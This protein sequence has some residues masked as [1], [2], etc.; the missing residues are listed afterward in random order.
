MHT[1]M[2]AGETATAEPLPTD[3]TDVS[4]P[5]RS[6][7]AATACAWIAP[8]AVLLLSAARAIAGSYPFEL[9]CHFQLQY[10]IASIVMVLLLVT[11]RRRRAAILA[12]AALIVSGS[13]LV[14]LW[15]TSPNDGAVAEPTK[16]FRI[17]H[18]N[19]L[20][21][22]EQTAPLLD[23]IAREQPDLLALH[24]INA[25]WIEALAVLAADYPYREGAQRELPGGPIRRL[26]APV[27]GLRGP[28]GL[29]DPP[30]RPADDRLRCGPHPARLGQ[31]SAPQQVAQPV[32]AVV[33][34]HHGQQRVG[35]QH[36][37]GEAQQDLA[38]QPRPPHGARYPARRSSS[39]PSF[40]KR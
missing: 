35:G 30:G 33:E 1:N 22:N 8:L 5:P 20:S 16:T 17:L 9:L 31:Q 12:G 2:D 14:P 39:R 25:R 15:F 29:H 32:L 21:S 34:Q 37:E 38:V 40:S 4:N 11:L 27:E 13:A 24:E 28:V 3:D 19:V 6:S 23:L 7:K 10:F 36:D 26:D 18:A